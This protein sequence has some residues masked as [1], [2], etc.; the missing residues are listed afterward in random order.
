MP[1]G[2]PSYSEQEDANTIRSMPRSTQAL[3][4]VFGGDGVHLPVGVRVVLRGRIVRQAREVDHAVDA[5]EGRGGDVAH[6]GH[7]DFD[8]A[9]VGLERTLAPIEAVEQPD[10]VPAL[11]KPAR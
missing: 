5:V 3:P 10:V 1:A 7:L 11:E 8:A 4:S 9:G 2:S 6:V